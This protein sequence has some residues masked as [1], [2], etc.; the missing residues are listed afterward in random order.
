MNGSHEVSRRDFLRIIPR[1][2][3][4]S[5]CIFIEQ[6]SKSADVNTQTIEVEAIDHCTKIARI[7]SNR[8]LAWNGG[9]CQFC[10][11]ACPLRDKA[12]RIEDQQPIINPAICDGCAKCVTACQTVNSTSAIKM[13]AVE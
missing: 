11:L 1:Y 6:F 8:C 9:S 12:I 13:V 3:T 7:D 10:Y 2:L 4:K 5:V